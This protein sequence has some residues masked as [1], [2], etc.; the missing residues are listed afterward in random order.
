MSVILPD[1]VNMHAVPLAQNR[2]DAAADIY[3][4]NCN[5]F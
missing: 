1:F 4:Q 2:G 3:G 5:R